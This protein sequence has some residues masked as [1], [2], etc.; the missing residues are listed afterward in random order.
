MFIHETPASDAMHAAP[1]PEAANAAESERKSERLFFGGE[2]THID[3]QFRPNMQRD[4][5]LFKCCSSRNETISKIAPLTPHEHFFISGPHGKE[6]Q[7]PSLAATYQ[8]K[9]AAGKHL[10]ARIEQTCTAF[11]QNFSYALDGA[12]ADPIADDSYYPIN[13]VAQ[14]TLIDQLL[15]II[16]NEVITQKNYTPILEVCGSRLILITTKHDI[17][18][19]EETGHAP[20]SLEEGKAES[21]SPEDE[22]ESKKPRYLVLRLM[23]YLKE[24][25]AEKSNISLTFEPIGR[26]LIYT[27]KLAKNTQLY[28]AI[29]TGK[30]AIAAEQKAA[31]T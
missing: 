16:H 23:T 21:A 24:I 25:I 4:N 18:F 12:L 13:T 11:P 27:R 20:G 1:E 28:K 29:D 9:G 2:Y 22:D 31:T 5:A 19:T 3:R 15:E 6:K 26:S 10:Y 17:L 7:Q 30:I 8:E 14:Y